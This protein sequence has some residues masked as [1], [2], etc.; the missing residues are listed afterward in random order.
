M[1]D[2]YNETV[3]KLPEDLPAE[4]KDKMQENIDADKEALVIFY[5]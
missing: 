1:P 4:I 3:E 5:L 2:W